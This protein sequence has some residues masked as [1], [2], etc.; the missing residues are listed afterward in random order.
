MKRYIKILAFA[1]AFAAIYIIGS[2]L[3]ASTEFSFRMWVDILGKVWI[4]WVLPLLVMIGIGLFLRKPVVKALL[5]TVS[6]VVYVVICL[7][8]GFWILIFSTN[9]ERRLTPDLLATGRSEFL[10]QTTWIYERPVAVFFKTPTEVTVEDKKKYLEEKYDRPFEVWDSLNDVFIQPEFPEVKTSVELS[11][12]KF[13]DDFFE[14]VLAWCLREGAEVLGI[15]REYYISENG[16]FYML[17]TD[18]RDIPAFAEDVSRLTAYVCS[19]TDLFE[20]NRGYLYFSCKEGEE[21]LNGQISF[22]KLGQWDDMEPEYYLNPEKLGEYV[23]EKYEA[24]REQEAEYE[25]ASQDTAASDGISGSTD[26]EG[27]GEDSA[28]ASTEECA[29]ILYDAVFKDQ[30]YPCNLSYT[31][32][33][34]LYLD[35]GSR[36]AGQEGDA[37]N[38]GTYRFT[39]VYDRTSKNGACELFVLYKEHYTE[40]DGQISNDATQILDMYAVETATGKTAASGRHAWS[41]VGSREY[42]DLT[43][44]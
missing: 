30:G 2:V 36:D 7:Y 6:T 23:R 42:R 41:D 38:T 12:G 28:A 22:G 10:G 19:R 1:I 17:L 44:E 40:K 32:K 13:Q 34:N 33:G 14:K 35:L 29:L 9:E 25:N 24:L 5:I 3:L 43:G 18:E 26:S 21:E 8:F 15:Q 20:E 11:G 27:A 37:L 39:L 4:L 31:A 16:I